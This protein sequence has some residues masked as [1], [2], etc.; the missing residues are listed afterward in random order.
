MAREH[1][2]NLCA[3]VSPRMAVPTLVRLL[4]HCYYGPSKRRLVWIGPAVKTTLA[5]VAGNEYQ[6]GDGRHRRQLSDSRG[7]LKRALLA[8]ALL[9]QLQAASDQVELLATPDDFVRLGSAGI[10]DQSPRMEAVARQTRAALE[11][12]GA[13]HRTLRDSTNAIWRHPGRSLQAL[14]NVLLG[15]SPREQAPFDSTFFAQ[16]PDGV[17]RQF[18]GGIRARLKVAM[19]ALDSNAMFALR[20]GPLEHGEMEISIFDFDDLKNVVGDD[21]SLATLLWTPRWYAARVK[22][23]PSSMIVERPIVA[24]DAPSWLSATSFLAMGDSLNWFVEASVMSYR[25]AGGVPLPQ[26]V[27]DQNISKPFERTVVDAFRKSGYQAGR[28]TPKATWQSQ[29]GDVHL[30]HPDGAPLPGEVDCLAV[31]AIHR[32]AVVAE[33]KV[34]NF[35]DS[36]NRMRNLLLKLRQEDAEAFFSKLRRKIAWLTQIATFTSYR[37][38]GVIVLDRIMPGT[39]ENAQVRTLDFGTLQVLLDEEALAPS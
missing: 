31:D 15:A 29:K 33:C 26:K 7:E 17:S 21:D 22:E 6:T 32:T 23:H 11:R 34:L 5:F 4:N 8:V 28:V 20:G 16:I 14:D 36:V 13:L 39:I 3:Q 24:I 38:L 30:V 19:S 35:P 10:V 18:W 12:R 25:G 27:F 9:E 2:E 37:F 1:A